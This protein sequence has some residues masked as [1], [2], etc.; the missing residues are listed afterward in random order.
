MEIILLKDVEHLGDANDIVKVKAGYGRNFLIP[1]GLAIP[2]SEG[3]K[4]VHAHLLR[5]KDSKE[6]A[7]TAEFRVIADKLES[8]A[9]IIETK[10]G[11]SG[12]IFGS[13][14][15]VQIAKAV[16][17]TFGED[18]ERRKFIIADEI[19]D[20]GAYDIEVQLSKE[21]K[22]KLKIEVVAHSS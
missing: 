16:K 20:L 1:Q 14:S 19:K 22:A 3:N 13:V 21:V 11:T 10:A 4:K 8:Q 2:A 6:A 7:M 17:E 18:I 15:N 5:I 9:V 12:K